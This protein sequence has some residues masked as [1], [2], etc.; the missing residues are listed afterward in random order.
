VVTSS[1]NAA[2]LLLS[3]CVIFPACSKKEV[4][5]SFSGEQYRAVLP[6]SQVKS[7]YYTEPQSRARYPLIEGNLSNLSSQ[8]VIVVEFTL[9]FKD[10]LQKTIHEE[11]AY[12]VFVSNFAAPSSNQALSPGQK[13]R[14]AF[15]A[16]KCPPSWQPGNVDIEITKVVF[17]TS[18]SGS[19]A[20]EVKTQ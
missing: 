19:V 7:S 2:L 15:K 6:L 5:A 12:P 1:R 20:D 14:F 9:R 3:C 4:E 8:T 18:A 11:H 10:S 13:T 16:P 17:A